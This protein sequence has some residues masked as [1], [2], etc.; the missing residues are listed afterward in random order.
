MQVVTTTQ[1]GDT[2]AW[3]KFMKTT[4][5][6]VM[7]NDG[8]PGIKL[9]ED[10]L[11]PLLSVVSYFSRAEFNDGSNFSDRK[12]AYSFECGLHLVGPIGCFKTSTMKIM[13][14]LLPRSEQFAMVSCKDVI[15]QYSKGKEAGLEVGGS[16]SLERF[17]KKKDWCF[18]DLGLEN[19]GKHYGTKANVM[20]DVI[21]FRY[22]LWQNYRIKTH[23]TTNLGATE[24][25]KQYGERVVDRIKQ[26]TNNIPFP[27]GTGMRHVSKPIGVKLEQ[28][29]PMAF[30]ERAALTADLF[31]DEL[32]ELVKSN[33]EK[34]KEPEEKADVKRENL[35]EWKD[36]AHKAIPNASQIELHQ[37]KESLLSLG[38]RNYNDTIELI[39]KYLKG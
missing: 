15:A 26:M 25:I 21:A 33:V 17:R 35:D 2:G 24:L 7:Q 18:D 34:G 10:N 8:T 29:Q 1:N 39:D 4:E 37:M 28:E 9:T 5:K 31:G 11:K 32:R 12:T 27:E 22:D 6:Y 19:E 38:D 20:A 14:R 16:V 36:K 23:F 3:P 13:Q 30:A